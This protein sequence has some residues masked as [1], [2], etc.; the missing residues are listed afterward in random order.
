MYSFQEDA[1]KAIELLLKGGIVLYPTD[2][3]WGL[4]CSASF[5]ESV[6][7]IFEIKRRPI[8]KSVILLVDS[9]DMLKRYVGSIH[10]RVETLMGYHNRPMTVIYPEAKNLDASL[11]A[12]DGSIA[13]RICRDPFCQSLIRGIDRPLISTSANLSGD[14]PPRYFSDIPKALLTAVDY[15]VR[16]RQD[17]QSIQ[18]P[19]MIIRYAQDGEL[20]FIRN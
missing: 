20:E 19:S 1:E 8:E 10:P 2:T 11:L 9:L 7:R 17:D 4:G 16:Y 5:P 18:E 15:V 14:S 12:T 13:I 6:K 3:I